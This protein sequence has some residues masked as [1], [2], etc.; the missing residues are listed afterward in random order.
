[1]GVDVVRDPYFEFQQALTL[2]LVDDKDSAQRLAFR[3]KLREA[4]KNV[5]KHDSRYCEAVHRALLALSNG[6]DAGWQRLEP[7]R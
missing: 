1:M 5:N 6:D 7:H 3:I 4:N 2:V